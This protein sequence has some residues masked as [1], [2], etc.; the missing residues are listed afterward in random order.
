MDPAVSV[1]GLI[2]IRFCF[3]SPGVFIRTRVQPTPQPRSIGVPSVSICRSLCIIQEYCRS[4]V[5]RTSL[6]IIVEKSANEV[7]AGSRL[8]GSRAIH[9]ISLS[10]GTFRGGAAESHGD[11]LHIFVVWTSEA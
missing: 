3:L 2:L 7:E 1:W 8:G 9:L 6:S 4:M 11:S 10:N 5:S